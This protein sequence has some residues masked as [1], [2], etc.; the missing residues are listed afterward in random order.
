[1][2]RFLAAYRRRG[3]PLTLQRRAVVEAVPDRDDHPDPELTEP[4]L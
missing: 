1:M 2:Q 4:G 3:L